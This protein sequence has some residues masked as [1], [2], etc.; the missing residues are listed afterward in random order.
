MITQLYKLDKSRD[1]YVMYREVFE[2][3]SSIPDLQPPFKANGNIIKDFESRIE[4]YLK[5][6]DDINNK[7]N[8][9]IVKEVKKS[10]KSTKSLSEKIIE[11]LRLYLN[12]NIREAYKIFDQAITHTRINDHI[13]NMTVPLSDFCHASK[14][15]FRVRKNDTIIK[16]REDIFHIPFPKRHLVGAQRYSVS[17]L[18]CLYL[19]TSIFV[20]WQEMEK[21]DFDKLYVSSFISEVASSH[22]ILNIG[23]NLKSA[24][25]KS[26][27]DLWTE[28][29]QEGSINRVISNLLAWPLVLACNYTKHHSNASFNVEYIIPNLLMQWI[30]GND[31][32]SIA[33]IAYRTTK[34]LNQKDSDIG[35]NII[36]PPKIDNI[37]ET[38]LNFCPHLRSIFKFTKPVSWQV[39]STLNLEPDGV[40]DYSPIAYKTSA[41]TGSIDDFDESLV[42]YY[43]NTSFKKIQLLLQ[44]MMKHDYLNEC[45]HVSDKILNAQEKSR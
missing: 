19:G 6:I 24:L 45:Q 36:M 38:N 8:N 41:S 4:I 1:I 15:L 37:A 18:P 14:P 40:D 17:G 20:C 9:L 33:G 31:N 39:F 21:P 42:D 13:Y 25:N 43:K 11:T 26:P 27:I 29:D 34:I 28:S 30:S 16:E 32:K 22:R 10:I 23:Y 12:G 7:N 5:A 44:R 35:I 2:S 3:L